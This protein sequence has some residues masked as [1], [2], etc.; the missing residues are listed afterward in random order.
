MATIIVRELDPRSVKIQLA[1][2][3][4]GARPV[5]GGGGSRDPPSCRAAAE[6]WAG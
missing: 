5:H 6:H 2:Q 1:G 3:A 4:Q